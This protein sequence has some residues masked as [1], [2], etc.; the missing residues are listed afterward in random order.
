MLMVIYKSFSF[1]IEVPPSPD[2]CQ[3][4]QAYFQLFVLP[5]LNLMMTNRLLTTEWTMLFN[6]FT[7][8]LML[9]PLG[10]TITPSC[11]SPSFWSSHFHTTHPDSPII[12]NELIN[13]VLHII[14]SQPLLHYLETAYL[15]LLYSDNSQEPRVHSVIPLFFFFLTPNHEPRIKVGG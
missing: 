10:N 11:P 5:P 12:I 2:L 7:T 8:L 1:V 14:P 13:D 3:N 6:C 9:F 15:F 4:L